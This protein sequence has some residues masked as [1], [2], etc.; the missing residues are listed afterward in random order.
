MC[1]VCFL[2]NLSVSLATAFDETQFQGGELN[3]VDEE[4]EITIRNA[5]VN[6]VAKH[7]LND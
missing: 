5:N 1:F 4:Q 2:G 6:D 7:F 3:V